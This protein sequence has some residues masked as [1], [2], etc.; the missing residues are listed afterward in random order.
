MTGRVAAPLDA[1]NRETVFQDFYG[2][3]YNKVHIRVPKDQ[4]E[5][6]VFIQKL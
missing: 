4:I 6:F 3:T 2:T 1:Y 5:L